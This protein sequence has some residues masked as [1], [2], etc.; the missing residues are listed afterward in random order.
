MRDI[1]KVLCFGSSNRLVLLL[2]VGTSFGLFLGLA[3]GTYY[4][5]ELPSIR[6]GQRLYQRLGP[7]ATAEARARPF[8]DAQ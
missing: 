7:A 2:A 6:W 4:W 5:L 3:Y 8:K 1:L